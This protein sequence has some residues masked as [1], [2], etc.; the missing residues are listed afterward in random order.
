M[1]AQSALRRLLYGRLLEAAAVQH[2]SKSHAAVSSI[3]G[4]SAACVNLKAFL[5]A[6]NHELEGIIDN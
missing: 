4:L 6:S 1:L 2:R 5:A 3:G